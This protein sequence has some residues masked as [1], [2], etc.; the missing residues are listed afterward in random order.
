MPLINFPLLR[1]CGD[2]CETSFEYIWEGKT[3]W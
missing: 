3:G 2:E 1:S